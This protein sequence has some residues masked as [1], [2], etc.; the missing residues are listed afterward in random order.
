MSNEKDQAPFGFDRM[1]SIELHRPDSMED[2]PIEF[3][4]NNEKPTNQKRQDVFT[5]ISSNATLICSEISQLRIEVV[6]FMYMFA[7]VMRRVSTTT[8]IM[9]KVCLVH[10]GLSNEIC[11]NLKDF[12]VQKIEVEKLSNNYD[13]GHSLI[14]MLPSCVIS[15]FVGAW[16][17]KYSRKIP[18]IVAFLGL[19]VDGLGSTISAAFLNSRVE[20]LYIAALFTGISGGMISV[21]TVLYSYAADTTTFSKRTIKYALMETAF[22]LSMPLGQLAGGWLYE[23]VG[24][25]PVFLVSTCCHIFSL[26]WVLFILQETKGLDNKDSWNVRFR[27]F[28]SFQPVMESFRATIKQRPNK[29]RAQILLLILAMSLA[30][31]SYASTGSINFLYCYHLYNWG[32]TKFSTISS[33]FSVIGTIAM[34]ISVTLFKRYKRG[35][36]TLG[37]VGNISLLIKNFALGL[38]TKPEIYYAANLLGLLGGLATLAGR[39]RISKVASKDDIGKVFA[40]LTTAESILPILSTAVAAQIF[41]ASLNF[42]PGLVYIGLGCLLIAPL[43][44]YIWLS[45]LPVINYEEMHNENQETIPSN[46]H[47][48]YQ[49]VVVKPPENKEFEEKKNEA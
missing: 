19:I 23:W 26:G 17:D 15:C 47:E 29:G 32:N 6:M 28:W 49:S 27:N 14:Q 31:L 45:K 35:D 43:V 33:S 39:S 42:Y 18:L 48:I 46:P 4:K 44:I 7:S 16:S 34:L 24:Y 38:A 30:V 25:I 2:P 11:K 40:F 12:P 41:N 13:V 36:P 9:D 21:L 37:I 3:I 5:Y 8:L 22:G 10:L 20:F 1:Q